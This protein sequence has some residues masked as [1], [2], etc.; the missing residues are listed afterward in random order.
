M[1]E[2]AR[3]LCLT[4]ES[5]IWDAVRRPAPWAVTVGQGHS[6]PVKTLSLA[7]N[8]SAPVEVQSHA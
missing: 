4:V 3:Q 6:A 5:P 7:A 2:L 1:V 8:E